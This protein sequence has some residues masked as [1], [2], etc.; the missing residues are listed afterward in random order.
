MIK[1]QVNMGKPRLESVGEVMGAGPS[2]DRR[3]L[4]EMEPDFR[5]FIRS[6]TLDYFDVL[7]GG[8]RGGLQAFR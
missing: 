5:D 4:E 2:W 7:Q 8:A 1:F 6:A 3:Q